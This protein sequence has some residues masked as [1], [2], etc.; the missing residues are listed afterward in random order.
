VNGNIVGIFNLDFADFDSS[1]IFISSR[2]LKEQCNLKPLTGLIYVD[3][4]D[5]IDLFIDKLKSIYPDVRVESW[6]SKNRVLKDMFDNQ[7]KAVYVLIGLYI[8]SGI[9]QSISSLYILFS[10][11]L[12]DISILTLLGMSSWQRCK[13]FMGYGLLVSL[14]NIIFGLIFGIGL[15]NLYPQ[16][17]SLYSLLTGST[18]IHKDMFWISSFDPKLL[19]YDLLFITL[20]T[21]GAMVF[22]MFIAAYFISNKE[23]IRGVKE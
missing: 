11:R 3:Q 9:I 22:C 20:S 2:F 1:L 12:S 17:R 14:A 23:I 10:E 13:I 5:R 19:P 15:A 6:H 7:I 4:L 18:L 21:F 16:I 8:L